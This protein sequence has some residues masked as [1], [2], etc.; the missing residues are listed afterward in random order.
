MIIGLDFYKT[1]S[2]FHKEFRAIA[3]S[4]MSDG[5]KV[6]IISALGK[7]T[8]LENYKRHVRE[9]AKTHSIPY[10]TLHVIQ[11]DKD[12]EIPQLKLEACEIHGV[13]IYFDD[14]EDV[15]QKLQEN[16]IVAMRVGIGK[17]KKN[18]K[19]FENN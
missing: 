12:E 19:F 6:V 14:R 8:S 15:C 18:K 9:F 5:H 1:I 4:L 2:A 3:S 13:Q 16:G 7:S 17:N 10:D 11:F